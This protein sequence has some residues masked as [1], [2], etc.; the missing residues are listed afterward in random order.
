MQNNYDFDISD[1]ALEEIKKQLAERN[2]PQAHLRIGVQGSGCSG[3]KYYLEFEDNLPSPKDL[4]F[5]RDGVSI[6]ID[7]KSINYLNQSKLDWEVSLM[8]SGFR[9]SNPNE[10]S[11]CGCGKS[12]AF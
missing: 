5:G 4:D 6:L 1:K 2:T 3:Y 8:K 10:K 7:I 9:I 11:K 12:V